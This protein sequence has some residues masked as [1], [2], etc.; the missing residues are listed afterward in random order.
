[1]KRTS[2]V[3]GRSVRFL[4][5]SP[6]SARHAL[7][8]LLFGFGVE[9]ATELY[10]FLN[11]GNLVLG[12]LEYYTTIGTT[13]FG[14]YLMFLGLREWHAFHPKPV[15]RRAASS[16]RRRPW[17]GLGLWA[18]GT[19]MTGVLSLLVGSP[20][21]DATPSWIAWPVG[22]VVVLA[23]GSFFFDLRKEAQPLGSTVGRAMGWVA[24]IW[25][26]G[27]ATVAG[28]G[29]GDRAILLVTEFVTNWGALVASVAPILIAMSLLFVTYALLIAAFWPVDRDPSKVEAPA[30]S[31]VPSSPTH[32]PFRR[33]L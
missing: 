8:I 11:R 9:G 24:F 19:L 17:F 13:L 5:P 33:A 10:Q 4:L 31:V 6:V 12:P 15:P 16:E 28:L 22:G 3:R 21:P 23:F 26:L 18:G 25:S 32:P 29:V 14:F 20:G 27:V 7:W 2:P 1:M 30:D